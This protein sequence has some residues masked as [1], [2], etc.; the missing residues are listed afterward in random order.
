L[1]GADAAIAV[2]GNSTIVRGNSVSE[3]TG[4]QNRGLQYGFRIEGEDCLLENN[5]VE[6]YFSGLDVIGTNHTVT[7]NTLRT[8][9]GNSQYHYVVNFSAE[10]RALP[11]TRSSTPPSPRGPAEWCTSMRQEATPFQATLSIPGRPGST[12]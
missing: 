9:S 11:K 7:G 1:S 12:S 4:V 8:I 5:T 6:Q 10:I 3:Y 2:Y